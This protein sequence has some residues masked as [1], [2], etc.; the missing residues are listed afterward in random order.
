M[1]TAQRRASTSKTRRRRPTRRARRHRQN[2]ARRMSRRCSTTRNE[3]DWRQ[4]GRDDDNLAITWFVVSTIALTRR[5]SPS[6]V[7]VVVRLGRFVVVDASLTAMSCHKTVTI[8]T[9][10]SVG[11]NNFIYLFYI[12]FWCCGC[13][14]NRGRQ[15]LATPLKTCQNI[16]AGF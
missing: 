12:Q 7:V 16:E 15:H 14:S 11:P 1:C 6:V 5:R 4:T 8:I 9:I 13:P 10:I 2:W 3:L